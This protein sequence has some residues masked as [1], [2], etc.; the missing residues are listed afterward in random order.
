MSD[1]IT[2]RG[3]TIFNT[4]TTSPR[5]I[6][7]SLSPGML[8]QD[9][10]EATPAQGI[11]TFVK[12]GN[13]PPATHTLELAWF[14]TDAGALRLSIEAL[15]TTTTG[16]LVLPVWGT[17]ARCRLD[18]ASGWEAIPTD[19]GYLVKASLSFVQYP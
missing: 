14:A 19:G 15:A 12:A 13:V 17:L 11:G 10:I 5:G 18:G 7:W 16:S 3:T 1:V 8:A 6:G 2:F 4:A 9:A